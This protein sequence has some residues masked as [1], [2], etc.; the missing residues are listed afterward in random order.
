MDL[1]KLYTDADLT[2]ENGELLNME[3]L[4]C[5]SRF[6]KLKDL[7]DVRF[8]TLKNQI[9]IKN[10][11]I[12]FPKMEINSSAINITAAGKHTFSNAIDYK[13]K[14]ALAQLLFDKAKNAKRENEEFGE[15]ADDGLGRV[16]LWLSMTGTVD[17]PVIKYDSKSAFQ[18]VKNDIKVEKQNLKQILKDEFGKKDSSTTTKTPPKETKFTVNWG[19]E[20][21]KPEKKTL[22]KP[23]K[24]EEEDY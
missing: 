23:K 6:T 19:E 20:K 11:A 4:K 15:V 5:L 10:Q 13:V 22:Q 8:A 14:L 24:A 12:S 16:N 1:D 9:E 3:A 17:K 2:I 7:D 18:N 21:K